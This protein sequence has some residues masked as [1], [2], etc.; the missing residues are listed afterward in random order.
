MIN[1]AS[2]QELASLL[3]QHNSSFLLLYKKG[4]S[5]SEEALLN[6]KAADLAEGASVY[7]CDVAQVRDVHLQYGINTAPAFLVFQGKRLAQV[8]KGT[9]TPAYYSQLIGGKTPLLSSRNE[10]N[11]PARVIVYTTPTCSWCNTLKSYLRSHQV[12]FSEIDVSRD[13]KMAAQ[14]VQRSGQ[15]G[16]PQTNIDGQIIIGFDRTRIDQLLK[17]N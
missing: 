16:V 8:I 13:E 9:Q 4:S 14:M 15:Q 7:L 6:L 10:Q 3:T 12:T 11:A 2:Y 5:L 17:I 1:I